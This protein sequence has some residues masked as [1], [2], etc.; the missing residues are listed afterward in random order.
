MV[1]LNK[2]LLIKQYGKDENLNNL[3]FI[4]F[5][6]RK[7]TKID[8]NTFKD[9][10][11][12][13][14]LWLHNNSIEQIHFR[15]F[16]SLSNLKALWLFSNTLKEI[17]RKCFEPLKSIEVIE[18]YK[19]VGLNAVSFIKASTDKSWYFEYEVNKYGSISEW[20][21]FLQ[22]FPQLEKE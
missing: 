12:V 8:P 13:E 21:Q 3:T 17:D 18:L 2:E 7:I 20:N 16:E 22:Q 5:A 15:L 10:T 11:K 6:A 14:K 4:D 19:N 1:E 9:L